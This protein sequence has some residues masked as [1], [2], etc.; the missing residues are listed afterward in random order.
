MSTP[1]F[2]VDI[3]LGNE[4]VEE[5]DERLRGQFIGG[6]G[7]AHQIDK[8]HAHPFSTHTL[9][10]G[11]L[12]VIWQITWQISQQRMLFS[13]QMATCPQQQLCLIMGYG[14]YGQHKSHPATYQPSVQPWMHG[15]PGQA[16]I[17]R[18]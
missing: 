17:S 9:V 4:A 8:H 5:L 6:A 13:S 1:T 12:Q 11:I 15:L 7:K 10:N 16:R 2:N 14:A 3:H 18:D